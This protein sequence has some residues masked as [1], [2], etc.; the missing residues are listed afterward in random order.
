MNWPTLAIGDVCLPTSQRNPMGG[1][2][3][4]YIDIAGIDR[5]AKLIVVADEVSCN[6][7]PSRARKEVRVGDVLVSMVRPNLNAVAQVPPELDGEIASTGFAVLRANRKIVD[8]RYLFYRAQHRDFVAKLVAN[9]TG[10]S[11]PAVSDAI[12][13]Q[14]PLPLPPPSEQRRIIEILDQADSLCKLRREADAKAARILPALFLKMFG[15]PATNPMGWPITTIGEITTLVTSGLTPRGG[16]NVYVNKGPMLIRSQNVLMNQ[17]DLSDVAHITGDTHAQ[18]QRTRVEIGDVLLNITG[19]SIGRVAWVRRLSIE[20]NVNQH[21]CI[22]RPNK[23]VTE[24]AFLSTC[25]SLPYHQSVI[26]GVQAGASRQALNHQQV[27]RLPI[28]LPPPDRQREFARQEADSHEMDQSRRKAHPE[29]QALFN[30]LLQ[31]AFSAQLTAEWRQAHM[32][33]L[34]I[35]MREQARLLN[36]PA[37]N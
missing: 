20:A 35:E 7:A 27:R 9:A 28:V 15:D 14:A 3:F 13:R 19:A 31:R 34:L 25:L 37:P 2:T 17:L 8:P 1:G 24:P 4:R 29:L 18:M 32:R 22:L 10:A 33:E 21:V 30:T 12:V 6:A 16:A 26:S 5:N 11:Y 23:E 36:L